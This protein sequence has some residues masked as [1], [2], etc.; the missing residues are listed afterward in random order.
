MLGTLPSKFPLWGVPR[1]LGKEPLFSSCTG[2]SAWGSC[3]KHTQKNQRSPHP[4][5]DTLE[6][7]AT[8]EL[9]A[10]P[11]ESQSR[12][13]G[14]DASFCDGW[15]ASYKAP[16]RAPVL[17]PGQARPRWHFLPGLCL[18]YLAWERRHLASRHLSL[19]HQ[20]FR[21]VHMG[22]AMRSCGQDKARS[23]GPLTPSLR[24]FLSQLEKVV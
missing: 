17:A 22:F 15:T 23:M 6:P 10:H 16:A 13:T 8:L 2:G 14:K 1:D 9:T 12:P 4:Q 5:T 21:F 3:F 18:C 7:T 24:V 11:R 19:G 20:S